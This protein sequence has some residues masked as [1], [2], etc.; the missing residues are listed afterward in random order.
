MSHVADLYGNN[1]DF[2]SIPNRDVFKDNLEIYGSCYRSL[3]LRNAPDMK[4]GG[5]SAILNSYE[6][7]SDPQPVS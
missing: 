2:R 6:N 7:M 3:K 1:C 5:R 4:S